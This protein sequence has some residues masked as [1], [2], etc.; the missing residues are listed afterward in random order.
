MAS[1]TEEEREIQKEEERRAKEQSKL[2]LERIK[3]RTFIKKKSVSTALAISDII[4][5]FLKIFFNTIRMIF[6]VGSGFLKKVFYFA[7]KSIGIFCNR[8]D[9]IWIRVSLF[10]EKKISVPVCI[11][12]VLVIYIGIAYLTG[13]HVFGLTVLPPTMQFY[14][15][16]YS[17]GFCS[18]LFVGAVIALFSDK[19]TIAQMNAI[20]NTAIFISLIGQ[21]VIVGIFLR[22]AL[23]NK[24]VPA[25]MM[26]LLML[27]NPL[28]IVEN[29]CAPGLLDVYLLIL[30]FLWLLLFKTPAVIVVTP[31]F[32]FTGLAIHYEF[33][34]TFLP[35]I[36]T[37]LL[38]YA[39]LA[40][41]KRVRI[42]SW[43]AFVIGSVVSL[44]FFFYFVFYA[45]NNLKMTS[46]E[47][48]LY[49]LSRLSITKNEKEALTLWMGAP[50]FRTY[51]DYYIF[52]Q[53]E[54]YD[55]FHNFSEFFSTL[56]HL[57]FSQFNVSMFLRDL[58]LFSPTYILASVIWGKCAAREKGVRK[59]PY[60]LFIG[61]ALVLIP[62][63]FLSTDIWRWFSATLLTQF[64]VFAVV[65]T[66][67][68]ALVHRIIDKTE[69]SPIVGVAIL[70]VVLCYSFYGVTLV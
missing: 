3:R 8:L 4:K 19:V 40:E 37:L 58:V 13:F 54:G 36:L 38:Y 2:E 35:P 24:S 52:G 53:N 44:V 45:K 34:F 25:T 49:M 22:I 39:F 31:I 46:D 33:L 26:G 11:L 27:T 63:L 67:K 60:I 7:W 42:E 66:D 48:Y 28:G 50:L 17:V 69:I 68:Y 16:D 57:A 6:F 18:R 5:R 32:C 12:V 1:L 47:F 14:V 43:L 55:F 21:A 30:F 23:K 20:I 51:F 29:I 70:S 41:K 9:K 15:C 10:S 62:E 59:I 61:Q 64:F 56:N 65:Y